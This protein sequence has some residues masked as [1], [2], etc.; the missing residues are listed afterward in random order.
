MRAPPRAVWGAY[1]NRQVERWLAEETD[2]PLWAPWYG[3]RP[4][5]VTANDYGLSSTTGTPASPSG[6]TEYYAQ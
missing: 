3:G 6:A 2:T 5:L 4:V 1:W